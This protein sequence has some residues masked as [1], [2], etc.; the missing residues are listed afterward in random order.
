MADAFRN[1]IVKP[2]AWLLCSRGAWISGEVDIML[3]IGL[4][5]LGFMGRIHL[6]NF[7]AH[8]QARVVALADEDADRRAGRFG[9]LQGNLDEDVA[10]LR[11]Q[12]ERSFADFR[13]LCEADGIDAVAICLPTD[14]HEEAAARALRAGKHVFCEKP[15]A[16][17]PDQ[18]RGMLEA[19]ADSGKTLMIGHCLRFWPEYLA[20]EKVLRSGE[21][22][23]PLAASFVRCGAAPRWG[24]RQWF[25]RAQRSGGAVLDLHIHDADLC[26]WW[27]GRPESISAGGA[28]VDGN[29]NIVHSRW[30]YADGLSAQFES[31][32]EAAGAAPFY[33]GFKITLERATLLLDSRN[34]NGLQ[35]ATD[36]GVERIEV[37]KVSAYTAQD[38]YFLDCLAAGKP[39][40]RCPPEQS[41]A[42]LECVCEEARQMAGA[43]GGGR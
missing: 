19:A 6:K 24:H 39:V 31:A 38:N 40:D 5:G 37:E 1:A 13:D 26:V 23:R 28:Y 32:W 43:R 8:P 17:A 2:G 22:G 30:R 33:Y 29:P 12:P 27:W 16:L 36:K 35:L 15:M 20:V 14:L 9:D 34:A 10:A 42:T 41:L 4:A 18:G 7:L 3:R 11:I 21:Y 25:H